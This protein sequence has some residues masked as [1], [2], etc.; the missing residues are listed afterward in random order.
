LNDAIR[1]LAMEFGPGV[2]PVETDAIM[3][4]DRALFA[5]DG[6]YPN[7]DG[8]AALA[9]ACAAAVAEIDGLPGG[10]APERPLDVEPER[11]PSRG[12]AHRG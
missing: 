10:E 11:G 9:R 12:L 6:A 1:A 3:R 5:H 8:H 2:L 4:R 7:D